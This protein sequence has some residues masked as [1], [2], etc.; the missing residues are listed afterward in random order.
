MA[1]GV[2]FGRK[3]KLTHHRIAAATKR[4]DAGQVLADIGRNY[5]AVIR[6]YRGYGRRHMKYWIISI[7]LIW[8]SQGVAQETRQERIQSAIIAAEHICLSGNRFRFE[9]EVDG[10]LTIQ[11]LVPGAQGKVTVDSAEARGSQFFNDENVR[12]LVDADIRQ[13]MQ[14]EWRRVLDALQGPEPRSPDSRAKTNA[15]IALLYEGQMI[16]DVFTYTNNVN[17][18][19]Q[20]YELWFAKADRILREELDAGYEVQ[21]RNALPVNHARNGMAMAGLGYWQHLADSLRF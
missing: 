12:K 16:S 11:K 18:L 1:R 9:L 4:R 5:N 20:N 8:A 10:S 15:V 2:R 19:K 6:R 14:T 7:L 3:P 21:F 13:C 17:Q